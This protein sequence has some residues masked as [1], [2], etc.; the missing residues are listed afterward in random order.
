MLPLLTFWEY[1]KTE[2]IY[3]EELFMSIT[4]RT[5]IAVLND[6]ETADQVLEKAL[7]LASQQE[8]ELEIH[9]IHE[10]SF[11]HL[12]D[13]FRS[14]KQSEEDAVDREKIKEEIGQRLKNLGSDGDFPLFVSCDDTAKSISLLTKD[15]TDLLVLIAY[16]KKIAEKVINRI[17]APLLLIKG[18]KK[19]YKKALL[20]ID[21]REYSRDC[22]DLAKKLFPQSDIRLYCD[23]ADEREPFEAFKK[24]T[25]LEGYFSTDALTTDEDLVAFIRRQD[26]DLAVLCSW[27]QDLLT[28]NSLTFDFVEETPTDIFFTL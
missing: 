5:I 2:N 22:V 21:F 19:T 12:H 1:N 10:E 3:S 4:V 20:P 15:K 14:A 25:G 23:Y 27:D 16:H 24:E 17:H 28:L 8:A 9:Y 7:A 11:V 26:M 13:F 6:F 18:E